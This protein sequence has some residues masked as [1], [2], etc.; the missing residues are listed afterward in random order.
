MSTDVKI[1]NTALITKF[2]KSIGI[3]IL[4]GILFWKKDDSFQIEVNLA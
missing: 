1:I 3:N 4:F 2:C